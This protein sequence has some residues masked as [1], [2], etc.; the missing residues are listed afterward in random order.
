MAESFQSIADIHDDH[1]RRFQLATHEALKD[2]AHPSKL[3]APIIDIHRSALLSYSDANA[4]ANSNKSTVEDD[5]AG[6]A[7]TVL[8]ATMAEFDAYHSQKNEDIL[9]IAGDHLDG[10]IALHEQVLLRLRAARKALDISEASASPG[11]RKASIYERDLNNGIAESRS[12]RNGRTP[13]ILPA[14]HVFDSASSRLAI[15]MEPVA[16]AVKEGV[17]SLFRFGGQSPSRLVNGPGVRVS[18]VRGNA[19]ISRSGSVFNPFW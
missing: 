2:I 19:P 9:R 13:L 12:N 16:Q 17:G 5:I 15:N 14:A 6:R 3:Y 18:E 7:E 11:P 10:E 4:K 1:A 8:N